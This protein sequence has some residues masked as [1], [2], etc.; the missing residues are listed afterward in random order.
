VPDAINAPLGTIVHLPRSDLV[1]RL[2]RG[3]AEPDARCF[4]YRLLAGGRVQGALHVSGGARGPSVNSGGKFLFY[5]KR[6]RAIHL[7]LDK[8]TQEL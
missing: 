6:L 7:L 5:K 4:T 2:R 8:F 1:R 3:Q